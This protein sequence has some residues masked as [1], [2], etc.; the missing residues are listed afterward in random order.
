MKYYVQEILGE[1]ILF[2]KIPDVK[3]INAED[4]DILFWWSD[5]VYDYEEHFSTFLS[6]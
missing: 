3:N 6:S 4:D 1:D 2:T 5:D